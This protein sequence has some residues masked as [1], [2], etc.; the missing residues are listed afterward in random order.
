MRAWIDSTV[1]GTWP[2]SRRT[3]GSRRVEDCVF[4]VISNWIL[5][6]SFVCSFAKWL[7]H[8]IENTMLLICLVQL[9]SK[10]I[11]SISPH[12][13]TNSLPCNAQSIL[14]LVVT[15]LKPE[16]VISLTLQMLSSAFVWAV[17]V[18]STF[19]PFPPE[20]QYNFLN[21]VIDPW[22]VATKIDPVE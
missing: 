12:L 7:Q 22:R 15:K 3:L 20:H 13:L 6:L 17:L 10:W 21:P 5:W 1:L 16:G 11:S 18:G 4:S 19:A 14:L 9:L 2:T 8:E